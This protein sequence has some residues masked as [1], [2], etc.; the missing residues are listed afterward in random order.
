MTASRLCAFDDMPAARGQDLCAGHREELEQDLNDTEL[1][2]HLIWD[3]TLPTKGDGNRRG[4]PVDSAAPASLTAIAA[5]DW[6]THPDKGDQLVSVVAILQRW[7]VV[8][9]DKHPLVRPA[10]PTIGWAQ[11]LIREHLD[12]L[13]RT[14]RVEAF[15]A[16]MH[17]TAHMLRSCAGEILPP[18]GR[19]L[20]PHPRRPETDCGGRLYPTLTS[21]HDN[22]G[23]VCIDCGETYSGAWEVRRLGL[24][25]GAS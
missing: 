20:A 21:T 3:M 17:D 15:A 1:L 12:W 11:D 25:I 8:V 10:H 16:D 13:L 7:A 18:I 23:V 19:H 14:P 9:W 5:T 24:V 2:L 6:R 22:P 4:R